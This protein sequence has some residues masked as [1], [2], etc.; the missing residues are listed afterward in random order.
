MSFVRWLPLAAVGGVTIA[1]A[2][3]LQVGGQKL[4][5]DYDSELAAKRESLFGPYERPDG[6]PAI[7]P[8]LAANLPRACVQ[9]RYNWH[10]FGVD[11]MREPRITWVR[12]A[13]YALGLRCNG[14]KGSPK[15]DCQ[16]TAIVRDQFGPHNQAAD[17]PHDRMSLLPLNAW[18]S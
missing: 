7:M 2:H 10:H 18:T 9:E 6:C 16:I 17:D 12:Y 8:K 4:V 15:E 3:L 1:L 5:A 11:Q 14:R 13:N